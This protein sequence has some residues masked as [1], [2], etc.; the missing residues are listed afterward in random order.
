MQF[1]EKK[2]GLNFFKGLRNHL[3]SF[4]HLQGSVCVCK[5]HFTERTPFHYQFLAVLCVVAIRTDICT[6]CKVDR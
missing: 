4:T 6:Q 1:Q 2:K 3:Q 5:N